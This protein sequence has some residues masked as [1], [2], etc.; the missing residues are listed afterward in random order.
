MKT[1]KLIFTI[2]I[3]LLYMV[4]G[5]AQQFMTLEQAVNI[6]LENNLDIKV[7]RNDVQSLANKATVGNAGLLPSVSA[8]GGWNYSEHGADELNSNVSLRMSYTLFDGWGSI[9]NYRILNVQKEQGELQARYQIER[10]IS[11]VITGYYDVVAASDAL[12]ISQQNI[13]I[14][15]ERLARNESR[16]EFGKLSKLEVLNAK[17]DYNRDSSSYLKSE[18]LYGETLRRL[19]VLMGRGAE[20]KFSPVKE[21]LDFAVYDLTQLRSRAMNENAQYLIASKALEKE[22]MK[23]KVAKSGQLPKVSVNSAYGWNDNGYMGTTSKTQLTGGLTVS[24][25]LFDG[26]RKKTEIANAKLQKQNAQWEIENNMLE[27]ERDVVNAHAQYS[28]NLQVLRLEEDALEAARVNFQQTKEYYGLGQ[29]T[30]TAFREAQLN[31]SEAQNRLLSA[32][33]EAKKSEVGLERLTGGLLKIIQI[34]K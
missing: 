18:L 6:A 23:L 32:K 10:V 26:K 33:Y 24:L 29:V 34:N 14:S 2:V 8:D 11:D 5:N 7:A 4:Q 22:E 27:L 28:N 9:Y 1:T 25:K 31:Y 16:F 30:A 17:V 3:V 21:A 15:R 19:N 13:E 12:R 20:E